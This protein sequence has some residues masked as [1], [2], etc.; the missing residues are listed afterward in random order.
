MIFTT[1]WFL[2]AAFIFLICYSILHNASVRTILLIAFCAIFHAHFAGPAGVIPIIILGISTFFLGLSRKRFACTLGI[3]LCVG[4]LVGYKYSHFLCS[5]L[6][7]L[8][9]PG[10]ASQLE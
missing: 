3:I 2:V 6:L 8:L 7:K 4:A 10:L 5:G 1:Y 9:H